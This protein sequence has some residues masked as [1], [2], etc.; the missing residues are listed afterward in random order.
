MQSE[1]RGW[2]PF[3]LQ[4]GPEAADCRWLYVGDTR[5]TNPFFEETTS[6]CMSLPENSFGPPRITRLDQLPQI[7]RELDA[8]EPSAFVFHVSRCGSTLV[9]QLLGLDEACVTLSEVPL[10]DHLLRARFQSELAG[11]V[12]VATQLPA[13]IRLHGQRRSQTERSLVVKLD[14]WHAGFHAELRAL[15]PQTPFV[16]LY[17]HPAAVVRSHRKQPGMHA[18][19]GVIEDEVFRFHPDEFSAAPPA[20]HL[21]RVLAFYYETFLDIARSDSRSLLVPYQPDMVT[22]VE[23][24]ARFAGIEISAAHRE[25]MRARAAFHAKRP[26]EKFHAAH[27]DGEEDDAVRTCLA[28]YEALDRFRESLAV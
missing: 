16:L 14:S 7:A 9:S 3:Q 17:R 25:R 1:L 22:A 21:P 5:F 6:R 23:T 26:D 10:F 4:P 15:Y 20:A 2:L 12:D 13:A 11:A 27:P 18:V 24:I 8:L 28:R 19:C